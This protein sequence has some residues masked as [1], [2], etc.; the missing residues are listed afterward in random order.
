MYNPVY[1]KSHSISLTQVLQ[2]ISPVSRLWCFWIFCVYWNCNCSISDS[3]WRQ[4]LMAL[5]RVQIVSCQSCWKW[6]TRHISARHSHLRTATKT[7]RTSYKYGLS[8]DRQFP[9]QNY[10]FLYFTEIIS[11]ILYV[12]NA[13][14]QTY[15][16]EKL[17]IFL[18]DHQVPIT[19]SKST[20][21]MEMRGI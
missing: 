3:T 2:K 1:L 19:G 12:K 8:T 5:S 21:V 10:R 7:P 20:T 15:L 11:H 9:A 18:L 16:S 17:T 13:N 6:A 14:V 4:H